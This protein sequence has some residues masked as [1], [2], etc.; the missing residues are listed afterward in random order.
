MYSCKNWNDTS[1]RYDQ[2][3]NVI[4]IFLSKLKASGQAT[5]RLESCGVESACC[6]VE[7]VGG[8]WIRLKP[9]YLGYGD[10]MFDLLNSS[11]TDCP[12]K[13]DKIPNN[14]YIENLTYSIEYFSDCKTD[15]HYLAYKSDIVPEIK[16]MLK[17]G[18]AV[19]FSYLTDY[20]SGHYSTI[21]AYSD[22][23]FILY[24][25]WSKNMHCKNKGVLEKF[26]EKFITDR[27]RLKILEVYKND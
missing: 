11:K 23:N 3:N 12:I 7:A 21:V 9:S 4:E 16:M 1:I 2:E 13:S 25:P 26:P 15:I 27:A 18:S 10:M 20:N 8:H 6:A 17:R 14:E 24:D 19:V 22:N 5:F